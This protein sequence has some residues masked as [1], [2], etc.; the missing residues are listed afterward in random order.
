MS[1]VDKLQAILLMEEDFNVF[2]KWVFGHEAINQL[3]EMQY[4]QDNQYSQRESTSED[5]KFNDRLTMDMSRQF[6]QP[7]V[8]ILA[9][10]DKCYDCINHIVISLL[11]QAIVGKT[12]VVDAML[13][14]IQSMKFFQHTGRGDSNTHTG[15]RS[16]SNPLQGLCQGNGCAPACWLMLISTIMACYKKVG[17]GSSIVSPMSGVSIEFMGEICWCSLR[18]NSTVESLCKL[19]RSA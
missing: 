16:E 5:S 14:P 9:D 7:L 4:V 11:L 15:G 6:R 3:Y 19:H 13:T 8:A 2:N 17:Y 18:M 10:A 1:L 12:G